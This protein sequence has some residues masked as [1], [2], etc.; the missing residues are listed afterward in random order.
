MCFSFK[1][2]DPLSPTCASAVFGSVVRRTHLCPVWRNPAAGAMSADALSDVT[3][4]IC[5]LTIDAGEAARALKCGCV[6]HADC[7]ANYEYHKELKF[8]ESIDDEWLACPICKM[9][10]PM[11]VDAEATLFV[12]NTDV[13]ELVDTADDVAV[14]S[15]LA[16]VLEVQSASGD[17]SHTQAESAAVSGGLENEPCAQAH[18]QLR[19]PMLCAPSSAEIA[20]AVHVD[21]SSDALETGH[22][23]DQLG[24]DSGYIVRGAPNPSEMQS[25]H[26][27]PMMGRADLQCDFCGHF[28]PPEKVRLGNKTAE[29]FRCL[30]CKSKYSN[31]Q[32]RLG[33]WPPKFWSYLTD[34]Q[35]ASFWASPD[36]STSGMMRELNRFERQYKDT[37]RYSDFGGSYQ[38]LSYW[39]AQGYDPR[40]IKLNTPKEMT[41][42]NPQLGMCYCVVVHSE[43]QNS[44]KGAREE[45]NLTGLFLRQKKQRAEDEWQTLALDEPRREATAKTTDSDDSESSSSSAS[46]DEPL[47][48]KAK[49]ARAKKKAAKQLKKDQDRIKKHTKKEER[50]AARREK[51]DKMKNDRDQKDQLKVEKAQAADDNKR[52]REQIAA[53]KKESA[54]AQKAIKANATLAVTLLKKLNAIV[55][56]AQDVSSLPGFVH[57]PDVV[58][59][60]M[61]AKLQTLHDFKTALS[62]VVLDG[63]IDLPGDC[64]TMKKATQFCSSCAEII[65]K[66]KTIAGNI[67]KKDKVK[68]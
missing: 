61:D 10:T 38:P 30:K 6:Y 57:V 27:V 4:T 23:G 48:E 67:S 46:S 59:A 24:A 63:T 65:S 41:E 49:L 17:A 15:T 34:Q 22:H 26:D 9:T 5:L 8:N 18:D 39:K 42:W 35:K 19:C 51:K 31:I 54:A 28:C 21:A 13:I 12:A 43:G 66:A 44:K 53:E 58:K 3:C 37:H 40:I 50:R 62:L 52:N 56:N 68:K 1:K 16:T 64:D 55:R 7:A 29:T 60:P 45:E 32:R 14:S 11:C 36:T 33:A 25:Q 47:T 20:T 2:Y